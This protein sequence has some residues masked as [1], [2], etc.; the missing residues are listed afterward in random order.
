[1]IESGSPTSDSVQGFGGGHE[2]RAAA[3]VRNPAAGSFPQAQQ[4]PC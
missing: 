4:F 3:G 1:V 2:R